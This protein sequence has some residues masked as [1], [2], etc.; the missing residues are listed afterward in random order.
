MVNSETSKNGKNTFSLVI[1]TALFFM[2]GFI[3]C[4]NDILVPYMKSVFSLNHTQAML[5]QFSFFG[6]YFVGSLIYFI[7]SSRIGDPINKIGY[8]NGIVSGLLLS[9]LGTFLFL[10]AAQL[11]S[12]TFFLFALFI[13]GLGFTLLQ[14]A[15]NPYVAI[16]GKPETASSRLN[17]SQ[18]FNSLGTTIAPLIGGFLIFT[19]FSGS[20]QSA[21]AVRVPYIIFSFVF[22]CL[23]IIF[24]FIHLPEFKSHEGGVHHA[25]ALYYRHLVLG[26]IA[27]F[28]YV[29][30]EVSI[31]SMMI[32]FIGLK[33]IA[34]LKPAEASV[35]VA[36]YWGGLMIGRFIGAISLS[37]MR[38][39][40]KQLLMWIIPLMVFLF[41]WYQKGSAVSVIYTSF[42][43]LSIIG[44][45]LGKFL[46][47]RTLF[48]FSVIID[49]LIV[50]ALLSSGASAMW[51]IIAVGLFN[52][53]MWSNIFTLAIDGLGVNTSQGSSLLVMAILGGALLPVL[54][55]FTADNLGVHASFIV[56]F[57]AYI[58]LAYYGLKGYKIKHT[59]AANE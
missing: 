13:L 39:E 51:C 3:T 18:G 58:Y 30:A 32:S 41:I 40:I 10:P 2:W 31:G 46:P 36:F 45:Y 56:P 52:S 9:S 24:K 55:G 6:A 50:I 49:I 44:F 33:E 12:Y 28:L 22:L 57:F 21:G 7:I 15:A 1:L 35:F 34:G 16:I 43:V 11:T 19:Y 4:M 5:I 20:A 48:V 42:I 25:S 8:K 26:I 17:L 59:G 27:I 53:I 37:K 29:G 23:A 38:A 14:I 47:A 54:Q